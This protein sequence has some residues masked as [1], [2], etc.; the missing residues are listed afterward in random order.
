MSP[1]VVKLVG[2]V[3]ALTDRGIRE[4]GFLF[5]LPFFCHVVDPTRAC[6]PGV[7]EHG[8]KSKD[9]GVSVGVGVAVGVAVAVAVAMTVALAVAGVVAVAVAVAMAVLRTWSRLCPSSSGPCSCCRSR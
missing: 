2:A 4:G 9:Q 8:V 3:P 5:T 6:V 7:K 1:T